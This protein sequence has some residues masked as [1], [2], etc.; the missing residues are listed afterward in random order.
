MF[1]KSSNHIVVSYVNLHY[2]S[3]P[4]SNYVIP[5][6]SYFFSRNV[7]STYEAMLDTGPEDITA[8]DATTIRRQV[9]YL[10]IHCLQF[11]VHKLVIECV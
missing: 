5:K 2:I 4:G 8:V 9:S 10:L 7:L 11:V 1:G 6:A 3:T